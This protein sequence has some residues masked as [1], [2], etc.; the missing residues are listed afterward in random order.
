MEFKKIA[1]IGAGT[2][3]SGIA[4]TYAMNGY[5]TTIIARRQAGLDESKAIIEAS[6]KNMLDNDFITA[7][8]AANAA[9]C[10]V[11]SLSMEDAADADLVVEAVPEN[12]EV[13]AA[14]FAQ[15]DKICRPD[16]I[17][18]STTSAMNVYAVATVSNPGR[19]L[20][21]HWNNP[22]HILPLVEIVAGPE[23]D[24]QVIADVRALLE[25]M[26][27]K[28]VVLNRYIP[29]FICN[30]LNLAI[31]R[32]CAYMVEQGWISAEDVDTAYIGNQGMKAP[33]EGPLEMMDYIG[34]DV[35]YGAG[36]LLYPAICSSTE[37]SKLAMAMIKEGK[38]GVKTGK[39]LRDYSGRSREEV[40]AAREQRALEVVKLSRKLLAQKE[41]NK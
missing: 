30:R 13:K 27:K 39:G 33:F 41:A 12:P 8:Q 10:M 3:G 19:L 16:C 25:S 35:A 29:G 18:T 4:Q 24:P 6:V 36:Q 9:R 1:V 17:L 21:A 5:I 15:L 23:T 14:T 26:D 22:A 32:E 11:Y 7:E 2:M 38:L 31:M 28:P 37:P 20:I 34:W 40:Q